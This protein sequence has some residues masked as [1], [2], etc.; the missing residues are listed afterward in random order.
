MDPVAEYRAALSLLPDSAADLAVALVLGMRMEPALRCMLLVD[1]VV[2]A[3]LETHSAAYLGA[4][5][6]ARAQAGDIGTA[7]RAL[8]READWFAAL[9]LMRTTGL[10]TLRR[11]DAFGTHDDGTDPNEG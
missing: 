4:S 1:L 5:E 10:V 7:M 3:P 8:G 6:W 2:R 9:G 11:G